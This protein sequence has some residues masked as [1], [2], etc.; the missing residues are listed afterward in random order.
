MEKKF[1]GLWELLSHR[2]LCWAAETWKAACSK[3]SVTEAWRI[4]DCSSGQSTLCPQESVVRPSFCQ[5]AVQAP[6]PQAFVA[7][8]VAGVCSVALF[9]LSS[10]H[11]GWY[12]T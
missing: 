6:C 1:F 8:F 10:Q 9:Q 4:R 5:D 7:G 3:V 11:L 12:F 2:E